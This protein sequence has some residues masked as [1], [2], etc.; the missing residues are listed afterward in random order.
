MTDSSK[1]GLTRDQCYALIPALH[2][3]R[4]GT[5]ADRKLTEQFRKAARDYP[6]W[7]PLVNEAGQGVEVGERAGQRWIDNYNDMDA[8]LAAEALRVGVLKVSLGCGALGRM[9]EVGRPREARAARSPGQ[10][11]PSGRL[12]D[13]LT[14]QA[15]GGAVMAWI[16]AGRRVSSYCLGHRHGVCRGYCGLR[17]PPAP[18]GCRCHEEGEL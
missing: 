13:R 5:A 14:D 7:F 17:R 10:A 3:A 4:D 18:C 1:D 12:T 11:R 9:V 8:A 16:V 6:D 15:E 2:I